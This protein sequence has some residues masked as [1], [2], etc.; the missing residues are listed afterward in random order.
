M[1][2]Q[3]GQRPDPLKLL[4]FRANAKVLAHNLQNEWNALT[5]CRTGAVDQLKDIYDTVYL[6]RAAALADGLAGF[7]IPELVLLRQP[8]DTARATSQLNTLI[9]LLNSIVV[10]LAP[11]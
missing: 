7:D 10:I 2:H 3:S 6:P 1:V 11:N 4:E 5:F 9:G 8:L